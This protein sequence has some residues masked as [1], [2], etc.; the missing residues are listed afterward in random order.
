L[1]AA[2]SASQHDDIAATATHA[3]VQS[4]ALDLIGSRLHAVTLDPGDERHR[5]ECPMNDALCT[6]GETRVGLGIE[7]VGR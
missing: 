2:G 6:V 7:T 1:N 4:G 3:D 5:L